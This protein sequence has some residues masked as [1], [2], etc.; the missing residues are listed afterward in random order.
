MYKWPQGRVIRIV[1]LILSAIVVA[2]LMYHGAYGKFE[3]YRTAADQTAGMRQLILAIFFTVVGAA[4]AIASIVA[5]GFHKIAVDFLIDVEYEMTKVEWP[6]PD[7]LWKSTLVIG[8]TII[9]MAATL[10]LAD[11]GI[12]TLLKLIFKL[13]DIL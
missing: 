11:W 9:I 2:D 3:A 4:T 12:L 10:F 1:C 7:T 13:G 6:K 8:L 5:V